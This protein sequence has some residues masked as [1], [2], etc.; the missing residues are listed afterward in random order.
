V[1]DLGVYAPLGV[2]FALAYTVVLMPALL[3]VIPTRTP[4]PR[5]GSGS[6]A[7]TRCLRALGDFSAAHPW[8]VVTVTLA[9]LGVAGLGAALLRFSHDPMGWFPEQEDLRVATLF[10]NE[11]LDGVNAVE[12]LVDTG[13][14]NGVH[15]PDLLNRL[16]AVRAEAA[17]IHRGEWHIGK[18]V[19]IADV[20][21]EIHQALNENRPEYHAIPRERELVAQELLLFEN[22]GSDDLADLVDPSLRTARV[23]LLVPWMDAVAYPALIEDLGARIRAVLGEGVPI[24]VTGLVSVL[25][26]TFRAMLESMA[27]SYV[28][29]LLVITPLMILLIG[30]LGR[31]LL[32]MIPN[33]LPVALMLGGMGW[34]GLP[35]DGLSMMVGSIV[36]GLAV[37]DTIHFMHNFRRYHDQSG[38]AR[39][40]IRRTLETTGRALL[41]TS[42]VLAAG[43]LVFAGAYLR[44]VRTFGLLSGGAIL[45]ALFSNVVLAS[46][47]MVLATRGERRRAAAGGAEERA[48]GAASGPPGGLGTG[49]VGGPFGR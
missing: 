32:S 12:V 11:R 29:A 15:E 41:V 37:D 25:S 7:I 33:L 31:G 8:S 40:A 43:F 34:F 16:D 20:V 10:M 9:V 13:V 39:Q 1:A 19:S 38:D 21:K 4:S 6:D 26:K 17:R 28:L 36:I 48:A 14:E 47:L 42:L 30:H 23:T 27:R 49:S 2:M 24:H 18:S 35:V 5:V 46:S 22:S 3:A 44:N 45:V